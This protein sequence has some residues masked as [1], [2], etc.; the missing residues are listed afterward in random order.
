[1]YEVIKNLTVKVQGVI[2]TFPAGSIVKLPEKAALIF[3]QQGKLAPVF[4]PV[5]DLNE[6]MCIQGENCEPNQTKPYV[7][8]FGVLVIPFNSN[9]KYHYW[10][11][12]QSLCD[13]LKGLGRCDLIEKYKSLY[14]N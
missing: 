6:R 14:C 10:N 9:K 12:G 1:M 4:G 5:D 13:T 8:D 3:I 11:G 2:K 7:T